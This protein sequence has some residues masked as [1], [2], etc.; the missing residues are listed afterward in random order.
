MIDLRG[1][2]KN[3]LTGYIKKHNDNFI[4]D[5]I[6][7]FEQFINLE[8]IQ[9][10]YDHNMQFG[11]FVHIFEDFWNNQDEAHT[12]RIEKNLA[13]A[14]KVRKDIIQLFTEKLEQ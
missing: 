7:E 14:E 10:M 13:E 5:S 1:D 6:E 11:E 4:D 9:I 12:A 2:F 3:Q 8:M